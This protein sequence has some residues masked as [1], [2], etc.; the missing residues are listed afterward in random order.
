MIQSTFE[1][2]CVRDLRECN[3]IVEYATSTSTG[4]IYFSPDP[5]WDDAA[6]VSI[7]DANFCQEQEQIDGVTQNFKSQQACLTALALGNSLNAEK[8]LVHPLSWSLMRTRRVCRSTL[9]AEATH[10][11]LLLNTDCEPGLRSLT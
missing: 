4:G 6:V 3:R 2:A 1:N 11:P 7:S 5:S 10:Y 8:M 9:M